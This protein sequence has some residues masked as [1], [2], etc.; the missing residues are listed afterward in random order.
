MVEKFGE[1]IRAGYTQKTLNGLLSKYTFNMQQEQKQE[2]GL[3]IR[4]FSHINLGPI[5]TETKT[6][7]NRNKLK[8]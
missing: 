5:H 7:Q 8:L 6:M 4:V 1:L 2:K 3:K